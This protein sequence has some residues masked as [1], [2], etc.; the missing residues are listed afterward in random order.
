MLNGKVVSTTLLS[1][2]TYNA[3]TRIVIR[4]TKKVTNN[5]TVQQ[6]PTTPT[7]QPVE[8]PTQEQP[9]TPQEENVDK[10]TQDATTS[11]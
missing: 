10:T 9:L 5:Q 3:M 6:T 7:T 2:D 4:G 11:E 1:K 8:Q